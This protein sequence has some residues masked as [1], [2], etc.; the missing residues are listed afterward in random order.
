VKIRF[1]KPDEKGT[2]V[3]V[4]TT[5]WKIAPSPNGDIWYVMRNGRTLN[6]WRSLEIA[7]RNLQIDAR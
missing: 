5:E 2:V 6:S 3:A 4:V 1:K 7:K